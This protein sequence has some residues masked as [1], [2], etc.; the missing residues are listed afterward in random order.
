M[1][2]ESP[3]EI[4]EKRER[5]REREREGERNMPYVHGMGLQ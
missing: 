5:E 3:N 2:G 1:K 4:Q